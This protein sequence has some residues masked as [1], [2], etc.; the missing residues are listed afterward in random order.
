MRQQG[1]TILRTHS[2]WSG[3]SKARG[4]ESRMRQRCHPGPKPNLQSP[5]GPDEASALT[6]VDVV[7]IAEATEP[8]LSMHRRCWTLF[9]EFGQAHG[10]SRSLKGPQESIAFPCMGE[11]IYIYVQILRGFNRRFMQHT[12][13]RLRFEKSR[14]LNGVLWETQNRPHSNDIFL[15]CQTFCW[16]NLMS[17][18][19]VKV[20]TAAGDC[21]LE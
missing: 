3:T 21:D 4:P 15:Q 20:P 16:S 7:N 17:K 13:V 12:S 14:Y 2:T 5:A 8:R 19:K 18:C 11:G 9:L 1:S 6:P 10:A